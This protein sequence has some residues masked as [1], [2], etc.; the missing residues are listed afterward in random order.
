[1]LISMIMSLT[2]SLVIS[3]LYMTIQ[4]PLFKYANISRMFTPL[5]I[6]IILW[7]L[8]AL[9]MLAIDLAGH[10]GSMNDQ[11]TRSCTLYLSTQ[12]KMVLVH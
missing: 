12:E 6:G 3:I 4:L 11:D 10:F 9:S 7:I 8:G 5:L 1:M 2:G